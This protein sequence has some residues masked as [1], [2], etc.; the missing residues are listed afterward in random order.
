MGVRIRF[1]IRLPKAYIQN[2]DSQ[3]GTFSEIDLKFD[4]LEKNLSE[5]GFFGKLCDL[6]STKTDHF[7]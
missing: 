3:D 4:E 7:R 2:F 6:N 1:E 5:I